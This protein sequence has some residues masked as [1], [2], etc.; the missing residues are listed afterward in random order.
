MSLNPSPSVAAPAGARSAAAKR[1]LSWLRQLLVLAI[2]FAL[3]GLFLLAYG[4]DP[5]ELYGSMLVSTFGDL[6]GFGE[7]LLKATPF[8]LTGLAA[9]LPAKAGLVNVGGEGQ[10]AVGALF[11]A[12]FGVFY[13]GGLPAWIGIP[14]MLLAGALGGALWGLAIALLKVKGR[15]NETIT[16]VLL[17]YVAVFLVGFF[18][19]G[20]LKDPESFNWPFSPEIAPTL[21][22][23]IFDGTRLHVGFVIAAAIAAIVWFVLARTRLGYRIR[24]LGS[25]RLAAERAGMRI[26]RMY[27]WVLIAAG[28]IAGIAGMIEIA[29][30][31]GRLRATTGANFGYLGF[32][33]AMMAWNHPLRLLLTAFVLGMISV[34]GNTLE[35]GSGLPASA[36]TILMGLVLFFILGGK[37]RRG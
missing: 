14:A 2:P 15:L 27:F 29:G 26:G 3:F 12:W 35:I 33:A 11:A 10:L 28:A 13:L 20:P 1:L 36:V 18:V 4:V 25:N 5:L 23:P 31:E 19:H 6:Y 34:A 9:A 32:L 22:L 30:I 8:V 7:V 21:R 37:R 17:N 16:S 24:V